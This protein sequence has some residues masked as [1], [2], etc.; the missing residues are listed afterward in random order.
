MRKMIADPR[1]A[2]KIARIRWVKISQ[3]KQRMSKVRQRTQKMMQEVKVPPI[4]VPL[5]VRV[6][7]LQ[8]QVSKELDLR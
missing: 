4:G 1:L 8:V 6:D 3:V 5:A 7:L 2:M